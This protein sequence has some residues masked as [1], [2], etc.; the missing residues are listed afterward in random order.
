M[1]YTEKVRDELYKS[2]INFFL[3][4]PKIGLQESRLGNSNTNLI[5]IYSFVIMN[6]CIFAKKALPAKFYNDKHSF[7]ILAL[8][9]YP[10]SSY[11]NC[12]LFASEKYRTVAKR[13]EDTRKSIKYYF[14]N[15]NLK[16]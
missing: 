12:K 3:S 9:S 7:A 4:R 8:A 5:L 11:I 13:D 6:S 15:A 16:N 1:D 10:I 2:E 14:D